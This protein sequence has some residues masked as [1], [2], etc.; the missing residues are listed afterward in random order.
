M[1][2]SACLCH[3]VLFVVNF[4][5]KFKRRGVLGQWHEARQR[6]PRSPRARRRPASILKK[7]VE[8]KRIDDID[9]ASKMEDKKNKM[10]KKKE[11]KI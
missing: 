4:R 6:W 8:K 11:L 9:N 1:C 10:K 2:C 3:G 5:R 7:I